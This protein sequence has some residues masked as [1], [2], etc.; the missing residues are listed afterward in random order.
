MDRGLT[1][2]GLLLEPVNMEKYA[3][4][5]SNSSIMVHHKLACS[6]IIRGSVSFWDPKKITYRPLNPELTA[7]SV[8]AWRRRQPFALAVEKFIEHVKENLETHA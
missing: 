4:L 5:P 6:L 7:T 3:N 8:L 2:V 1:D